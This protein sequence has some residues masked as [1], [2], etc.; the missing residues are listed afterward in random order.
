MFSSRARYLARSSRSF[1]SV[2]AGNPSPFA[3]FDKHAKKMQKDRAALKND[4]ESSRT[5]DYIRN[6]VA[7]RMLERFE[8]RKIAYPTLSLPIL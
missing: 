7:D 4:G 5:V 2:A 8:V 3:V 1:A 6:E